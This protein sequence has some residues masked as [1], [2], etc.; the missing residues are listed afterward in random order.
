[1]LSR[2]VRLSKLMWH[3]VWGPEH[4]SM[5]TVTAYILVSVLVMMTHHA[6]FHC[7]LINMQCVYYASL[8]THCILIAY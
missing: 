3:C 4:A 1:M 7:L 6:S 8:R 2:H 5:H